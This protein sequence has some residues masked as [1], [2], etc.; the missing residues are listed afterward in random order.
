MS[1]ENPYRYAGYRYD[2]QTKLYYLKARYYNPEDGV[3]LTHDPIKGELNNPISQNGY[4]YGNNNPV[5]LIDSTGTV[6]ETVLDL[7]SIGYSIYQ[8]VKNP[9]WKTA[10]YLIWDIAAA[11][12]PVAPDSYVYK[13]G[14]LLVHLKK[15]VK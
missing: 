1:A 14:K 3:F 10:G 12:I 15:V 11:A 2:E 8:F 7:A 5:M 9:T 4:N 13:G 6:V